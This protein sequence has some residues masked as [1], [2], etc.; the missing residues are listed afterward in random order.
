MECFSFEC[1]GL[2]AT[3][4][5]SRFRGQGG[6]EEVHLLVQ[7]T[8]Y[9][10]FSTQLDWLWSAYNAALDSAGLT[11]QTAIL[12]RFFCSDLANQAHELLT[13]PF[14]NPDDE[15]DPCAVSWVGQPP[16][17]PA[18]VALWAYHVND[19]VAGLDKTRE[20]TT[21][22]LKRGE[23]SH[24]WTTGLTYPPADTS[25]AQTWGVFGGYTDF[26]QAKGLTLADHVIRTWLFVQNIDANYQGLVAARR[27]F[28]ACHGLTP[29]THFI[30]SSGI[31]GTS[32]NVGA[33]VAMDAYAIVGVRPEQIEYLAALDHLCPTNHYGVTFERGTALAWRDRKQVI[34]SGTA[35]I[36]DQGH[37]LHP[38]D[39]SRQLERTLENIEALLGQAGAT[40]TDMALFIVYL[41]DPS[42]GA[43]ACRL[44]RERFGAAP[45]AVVTAPVCRP[46]W[47]IEVEGVAL[48]PA[49]NPELPAF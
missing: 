40:L 49:A 34:L 41:R 31:E 5:L 35:S 11:M 2:P 37:I 42:D 48:I 26:L 47:L 4:N 32:A 36:D 45:I 1:G 44:M 33:R 6:V 18:K 14:S 20:D 16:V 28:F 24:F 7:V 13:H 29:Q 21:L 38:G 12:R 17:P 27:E 8:E 10:S 39:V 22:I 15:G 23:L 3:V 43:V 25:Y 30:A 9:G 46:G 19:P